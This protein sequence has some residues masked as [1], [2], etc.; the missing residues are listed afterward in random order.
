MKHCH[1]CAAPLDNPE[2]KGVADDYCRYCADEKGSLKSREEVKNAITGWFME[3]QPE[4]TAK[5]AQQ[6][7]EHYLQ[8]MP[9]WA[10]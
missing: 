5:V 1:A 10:E 2:F 4:V 8:S 7:A 3:W 6:R 9:A